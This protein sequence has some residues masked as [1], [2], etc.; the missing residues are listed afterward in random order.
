[1]A[2]LTESGVVCWEPWGLD[3]MEPTATVFHVALGGTKEPQ[4]PD[5][6]FPPLHPECRDHPRACAG[7]H[8][9]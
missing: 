6:S 4:P 9:Q 1:M 2:R 7:R 3:W 8:A 5:V